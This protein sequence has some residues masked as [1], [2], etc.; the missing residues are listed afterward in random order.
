M[1]LPLPYMLPALDGS[2]SE[3]AA[4]LQEIRDRGI[5]EADD[6]TAFCFKVEAMLERAD[7]HEAIEIRLR[8]ALEDREI[9]R[10]QDL[11]ETI[12]SVFD[13]LR[14]LIPKRADLLYTKCNEILGRLKR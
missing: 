12:E 3:R 4:V 11:I 13:D 9:E 2:S 10:A 6:L 1:K 5:V 7:H 8:E 14:E